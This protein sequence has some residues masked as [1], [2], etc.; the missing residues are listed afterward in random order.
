VIVAGNPDT[1][2]NCVKQHVSA[3]VDQTLLIMQT[4]QIPHQ[5][6]MRSIELFGKD[7]IP[8]CR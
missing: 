4:D 2:I 7:V 8:A 3:G 5:K 1:C 6:V